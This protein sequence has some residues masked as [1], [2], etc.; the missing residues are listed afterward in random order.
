[1]NLKLI[2]IIMA[3]I[4]LLTIG[5]VVFV[6]MK[7]KNKYEVIEDEIQETK[8]KPI[9]ASKNVKIKNSLKEKNIQEVNANGLVNYNT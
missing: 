6:L 3:V 9:K 4:V 7:D 2:I 1:M 5:L 8:V